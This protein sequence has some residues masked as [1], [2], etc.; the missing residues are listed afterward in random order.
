MKSIEHSTAQHC[1]IPT[2]RR[3]QFGFLPLQLPFLPCALPLRHN[4]KSWR[5][6]LVRSTSIEYYH[7][8]IWSRLSKFQQPMHLLR[9]QL[10]FGATLRYRKAACVTLTR[11][12]LHVILCYVL[13]HIQAA[14][15]ICWPLR[16]Q[17]PPPTSLVQ[18]T[19]LKQ[20]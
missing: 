20:G 7:V 19:F 5:M 6:T 4:L 3:A 16:E 11:T 14:V 9:F 1:E 17:S 13:F 15:Q 18:W 10:F 2:D 12:N 8:P